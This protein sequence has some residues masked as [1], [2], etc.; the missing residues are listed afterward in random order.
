SGRLWAEYV[1]GAMSSGVRDARLRR[2]R[3][4]QDGERGLLSNARCLSE[5][6]DVPTPDGV[7]FID[8]RRS[9]IDI[10][11]AL[12]R[13]IRKAQDKQLGTIVIPVFVDEDEDAAGALDTSAFKHVWDVLKALRAHDEQLGEELDDLRRRQ[14]A[15]R[16]SPRRPG[17]IKLDLPRAI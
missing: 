7:A 10:I 14:G 4:I 17:K 11:Q 9:T 3:A 1:S 8:P 6:V 12:G 16:E 15:L 13:A 2:L 5:G